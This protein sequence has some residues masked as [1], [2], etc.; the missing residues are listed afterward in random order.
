[1]ADVPESL[2]KHGITGATSNLKPG[3]YAGP[4]VAKAFVYFFEP[5]IKELV[6]KHADEVCHVDKKGD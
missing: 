6:L 4:E 5:Q 2:R 3:Q 1:M